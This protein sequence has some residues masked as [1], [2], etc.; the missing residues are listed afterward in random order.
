MNK[1]KLVGWADFDCEYPTK[2]LNAEELNKVLNLIKEDIS[3]NYYVFS[4]H[5]HQY[6]PCCA[7]VFSDGTCFRASMRCW[8]TIMAE[9]YERNDGSQ[10][11][12]MDFYMPIEHS[13][14]PECDDIDVV[15]AVVEVESAGCTIKEDRTIIQDAIDA[16]IDFLTFDK[17]L[18]K[19]YEITLSE[20]NKKKGDASNVEFFKKR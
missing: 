1:L 18:L 19:R 4:G 2:K 11:S 7:P 10:Y 9:V 3:K 12:Y 16:G 17:V 14:I 13:N 5:E 6:S 20:K 8:G 15:P